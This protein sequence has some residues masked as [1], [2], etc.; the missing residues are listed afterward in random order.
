MNHAPLI[1][2]YGPLDVVEIGRLEA[3]VVIVMFHGYGADAFD[4]FP[5]SQQ[6]ASGSD[7]RWLF[8]QGLIEVP[9]GFQ[10][11]GRAWFPIDM[12][13]LNQAM[14][15]GS[16][17][18]FSD[19][20]PA[21]LDDSVLAV[22]AMLG[23]IEHPF[24]RTVLAGFSQGAMIATELSLTAECAPAGLGILSGTLLDREAW[25][26]AARSRLGL[27]F[28][29]SHGRMDPVLSFAAAEELN[30]ILRSAGLIGHFYPFHGGHEIP[31]QVLKGLDEL[32]RKVE[33][34]CVKK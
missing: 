33:R 9:I 7:V 12:V 1:R 4:L 26:K 18:N 28:V 30:Q 22:K 19:V 14:S 23:E 10:Q 17:R 13:A 24:D 11:T 3:K 21:G 29:Q 6:I 32:V 25:R 31:V 15:T 20:R 16:F 2:R 8:P 5:L 34:A 27:N